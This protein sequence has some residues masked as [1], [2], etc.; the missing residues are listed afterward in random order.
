MTFECDL[1]ISGTPPDV[2]AKAFIDSYNE[3]A[4]MSHYKKKINHITIKD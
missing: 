4:K 3:T 2:S 1:V